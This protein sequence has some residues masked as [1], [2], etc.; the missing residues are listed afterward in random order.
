MREG[1]VVLGQGGGWGRGNWVCLEAFWG[2]GDM[3][4][5][6]SVGPELHTVTTWVESCKR[7]LIPVGL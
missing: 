6:D 4:R 5:I 2:A 3:M 1:H 7:H